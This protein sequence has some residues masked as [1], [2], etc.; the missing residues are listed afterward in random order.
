[1]CKNVTDYTA[2]KVNEPITGDDSADDVE[3]EIEDE[4]NETVVHKDNSKALKTDKAGRTALRKHD[5]SIIKKTEE[6][7]EMKKWEINLK[8]MEDDLLESSV[9]SGGEQR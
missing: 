9:A 8:K 5:V 4:E 7:S 1:M 3:M 2:R 6:D